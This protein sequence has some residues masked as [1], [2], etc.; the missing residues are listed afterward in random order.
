M[1]S[2]VSSGFPGASKLLLTI[3]STCDLTDD[4]SIAT[5]KST[6]SVDWF[7]GLLQR[8]QGGSDDGLRQRKV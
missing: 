3:P 8:I 5:D 2:S 1:S 7:S 6:G 4:L